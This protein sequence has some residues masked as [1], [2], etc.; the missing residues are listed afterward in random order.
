MISDKPFFHE[1]EKRMDLLIQEMDVKQCYPEAIVRRFRDSL[2]IRMKVR[3]D[4]YRNVYYF[5][6]LYNPDREP[7]VFLLKPVIHPTAAIH[8]YNDGHLCLYDPAHIGYRKH[9]SMAREVLPLTFKWIVYYEAWLINGKRWLGPE[10]PH[11]SR[12]T[13]AEWVLWDLIKAA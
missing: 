6:A 3:D 7:M 9:F 5:H 2:S 8:M 12:I 10:T 11:G 1:S 4:S 13:D